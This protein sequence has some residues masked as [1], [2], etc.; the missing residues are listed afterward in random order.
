MNSEMAA[1]RSRQDAASGEA[2]IL[3]SVIAEEALALLE[4][5]VVSDSEE[6]SFRATLLLTYARD[7]GQKVLAVA[8]VDLLQ[9]VGGDAHQVIN[10]RTASL[11]EKVIAAAADV[12]SSGH[13]RADRVLEDS[14]LQH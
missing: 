2:P 11:F 6:I 4:A 8:L 13:A 5:F 12:V 7:A 9:E 10:E 1:V 3:S 14:R